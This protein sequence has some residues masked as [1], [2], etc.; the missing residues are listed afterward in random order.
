MNRLI[1]TLQ[2]NATLAYHLALRE[3]K[4]KRFIDLRLHIIQDGQDPIHQE[5]ADH[6]PGPLA[7]IPPG[8]GGG[9]QGPGGGGLV[10]PGR[11]GCINLSCSPRQTRYP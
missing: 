11:L 6:P 7:A 3:Y 5:G 2:K 4:G 10:G 8:L 9:G 1:T